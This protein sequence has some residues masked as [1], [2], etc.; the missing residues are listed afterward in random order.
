MTPFSIEISKSYREKEWHDDIR[1][2]LLKRAGVGPDG[3]G[4]Q[5]VAFLFSDTQLVKESFL[6]DI[7]NLLNS[8]EIPNLFPP[9]DK[10]GICDELGSKA[11]EAGAGDSRDA[12]YAYF[13]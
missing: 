10:A 6:E 9:E 12:I 11:R 8:G 5:P 7:N 1:D 4:G 2:N 3:G 13:V